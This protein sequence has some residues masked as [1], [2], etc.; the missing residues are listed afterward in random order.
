MRWFT[1]VKLIVMSSLWAACASPT[2]YGSLPVGEKGPALLIKTTAGKSLNMSSL[3]GKVVLLDFWASWCGP[4]RL[5]TPHLQALSRKYA[6][7][8][9]RLI[10]ISLGEGKELPLA[11]AKQYAMKY[12]IAYTNRDQARVI[13][14]Q[15]GFSGIPT[16]MLIDRHGIIRFTETGFPSVSDEQRERLGLMEKTIKRLLSD[17]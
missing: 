11:Y 17:R 1:S 6:K 13:S 7:S 4:C 12:T 9:L 3:R 2:A 10:G 8:G 15:F 14:R 5:K 16:T